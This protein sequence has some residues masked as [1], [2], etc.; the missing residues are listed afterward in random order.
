MMTTPFLVN[1]CRCLAYSVH[2]DVSIIQSSSVLEPYSMPKD[3]WNPGAFPDTSRPIINPN[4]PRTELNISI[5]STLTNLRVIVSFKEP[6]RANLYC[7][8]YKLGS[9]ASASAALL[10]L[11]PTET[12]HIRLHIPTVNPDQKRA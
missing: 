9:A 7:L 2:I 11:I 4:S 1:A 10:P 3:Y 5:T 8:T 12:P 6:P